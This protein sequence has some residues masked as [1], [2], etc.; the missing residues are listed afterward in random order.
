M[1]KSSLSNDPDRKNHYYIGLRL[2][3]RFNK[4][5]FGAINYFK[6]Q[7]ASQTNQLIK[8]KNQVGMYHT[9][10]L[11]LGYLDLDTGTK[12]VEYLKVYLKALTDNL[13]EHILNQSDPRLTTE[14]VINPNLKVLESTRSYRKIV[15]TYENYIIEN[16][17]VPILRQLTDSILTLKYSDN[18]KDFFLPHINIMSITKDTST[19]NIEAKI[20]NM[21]VKLPNSFKLS[22]IDIITGQNESRQGRAS[23]DDEMKYERIESFPIKII[24]QKK[25]VNI[26]Q[27][28]NL[29]NKQPI[30]PNNSLNA[31]P[32]LFNKNNS[33]NNR[34]PANNRKP[35]NNNSLVHLSN[36]L[37]NNNQTS[38]LGILEN[39]ARQN[40][41]R[42]NNA[43]QNN[44]KQNTNRNSSPN[45][46]WNSSLD[47]L[48]NKKKQNNSTTINNNRNINN[49]PNNQYHIPQNVARNN[50]NPQSN[51]FPA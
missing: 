28:I 4:Q 8:V 20:N 34:T 12:M 18:K 5:L 14:C 41:V 35:V 32:Q 15:V 42:Q 17:I 50:S 49:P 19:Q 3:I 51:S 23:K 6:R 7:V 24:S 25:P 30:S 44:V 37:P 36:N 48:G 11:Y 16:I 43:R 9:R 31:V 29:Q 27:H 1:N 38:P 45:N 46:L 21:N 39:N 40:N 2:D 10:F 33:P 47:I 22:S 26:G 13:N